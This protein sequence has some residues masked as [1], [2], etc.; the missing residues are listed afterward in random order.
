MCVLSD[1]T[2]MTVY[3][4]GT[5]VFYYNFEVYQ[6]KKWGKK[7]EFHLG[8]VQSE[9]KVLQSGLNSTGTKLSLLVVDLTTNYLKLV[10][11]GIK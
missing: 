4:N 11:I 8:E 7:S 6:G 1:S 3:A 5:L 10:I 2:V 9:P